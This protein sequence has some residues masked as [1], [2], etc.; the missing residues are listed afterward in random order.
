MSN[1]EKNKEINYWN[2]EWINDSFI[3]DYLKESIGELTEESKEEQIYRRVRRYFPLP[4]ETQ[5]Q[6]KH[7]NQNTNNTCNITFKTVE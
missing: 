3:E 2:P 1:I 4:D 6:H 7:I 5:H